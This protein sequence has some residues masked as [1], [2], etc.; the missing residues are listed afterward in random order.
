MVLIGKADQA[1][2]TSAMASFPAIDAMCNGVLPRTLVQSMRKGKRA[3]YAWVIRTS[4]PR[5]ACGSSR[6]D[7]HELG[8]G[9]L[10]GMPASRQR[11]ELFSE[12]YEIVKLQ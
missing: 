2:L 12:S 3:W 4:A 8:L 5:V 11:I 1:R 6:I 9:W 7:A 10:G